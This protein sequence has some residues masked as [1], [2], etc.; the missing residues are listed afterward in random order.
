MF[1]TGKGF[2][3]AT[4]EQLAFATLLE[5]VRKFEILII[6][7]SRMCSEP[8][9]SQKN[10]SAQSWL[11]LENDAGFRQKWSTWIQKPYC[12][13]TSYPLAKS[14]WIFYDQLKSSTKGYASFDY[15]FLDFRTSNL[16]KLDIL[17]NGELVD[18]L[19]VIVHKDKAYYQ[20]R[21]LAK[22]WKKNP[23]ANVW[24]GD[25]GSHWQ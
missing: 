4:A 19:S 22:N 23:T 16:A 17:L 10:S 13:N 21:E 15:E 20:G 8:S 5:E 18:A 3:W 24:G 14:F 1:Q 2:D 6:W 11:W 25:S 9:S 7:K 12:Y